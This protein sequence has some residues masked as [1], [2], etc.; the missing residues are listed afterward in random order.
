MSKKKKSTGGHPGRRPAGPDARPSSGQ[1]P[2]AGV[3]PTSGKGEAPGASQAS[4]QREAPREPVR[5][6]GVSVT[7]ARRD[8]A[9]SGQ[10]EGS[11]G[12]LVAALLG[13]MVFMFSYYHLLTLTQMTQLSG[14]LAMPDSML[15][16]Y[17]AGYIATLAG[18]MDEPAL[19]QLNWTH[20][21]A[22]VIFPLT[23]A[24]AVSATAA[25]C[26]PRGAGRW[27]TYAAAVVFAVVDIAENIAIESALA[28][29]GD[30]AG[31]ASTLT[32][33]R[34]WLLIALIAWTVL[35][36]LGRW[37]RSLRAPQSST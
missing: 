29:G 3:P 10:Q 31:L 6:P 28:A 33:V 13:T 9:A 5:H 22:G 7:R 12:V 4:G 35:M 16:G 18:V 30:G 26:L 8:L 25:W 37:R 20:K 11:P 24:A 19:G 21:T 27:V 15:F 36:L 14:G 23:V 17:D 34:W 2:T 1:S 32:V